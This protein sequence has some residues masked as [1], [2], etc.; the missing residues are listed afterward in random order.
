MVAGGG[1]VVE[2]LRNSSR[3][4]KIIRIIVVEKLTLI[5]KI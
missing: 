1:G 3:R 5:Q 2:G 4:Q